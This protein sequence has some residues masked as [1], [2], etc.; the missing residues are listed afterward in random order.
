VW[1]SEA[2][3]QTVDLQ[4]VRRFECLWPPGLVAVEESQSQHPGWGRLPKVIHGPCHRPESLLY[5]EC[6][7]DGETAEIHVKGRRP[8]GYPD[9][10]FRLD[11]GTTE[12]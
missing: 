9:R 7:P 4:W 2:D 11:R 10:E 1:Y 8:G 5:Q 6:R 12:M 3:E